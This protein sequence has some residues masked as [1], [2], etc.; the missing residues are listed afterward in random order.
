MKIFADGAGWSGRVSKYCVSSENNPD[1]YI[2]ITE[3]EYTNNEMEYRAV[4]HAFKL[5]N[6]DDEIYS[7]SQLVV[8]QLI[9]KWKINHVHLRLLNEKIQKVWKSKPKIRLFWISR[10]KNLAG[11]ILERTKY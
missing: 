5:A 9:K 8:N 11:K 3:H 2:F 4:L 10:N 1:G 6:D 7:D